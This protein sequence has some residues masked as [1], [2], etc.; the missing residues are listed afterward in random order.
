MIKKVLI[1]D[2]SSMM[3]KLITRTLVTNGYQIAGEAK[4]GVEALELYKQ[5]GPDLVT[6]DIT[7]GDMDG[8]TAAGNILQHDP[9]ARILFL[10]NREEEK[11][12]QQALDMGGL[13][14]LNKHETN[15]ILALIKGVKN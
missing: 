4:S 11:I 10:S 12:R 1:V 2:D 3:R 13:G 9:K 15:D 6:M 8:L 7:M 14:L 5:L